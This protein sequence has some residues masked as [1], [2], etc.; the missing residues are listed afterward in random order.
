MNNK[1]RLAKNA[2]LG[3]GCFWKHPES[4][5]FNLVY[6]SI[7]RPW[8]SYKKQLWDLSDPRAAN[9][10]LIREANSK[11]VGV[12]NNAK[13]LYQ[14][15]LPVDDIF[16][17]Y[18]NKSSLDVLSQFD[19]YDMLFW[20]LDDGTTIHRND[21]V[22]KDGRKRYRYLLS[23]GSICPTTEEE[24]EVLAILSSIFSIPIAS[25]GSIGLNNSKATNRNKVWRIPVFIA[26]TLINLGQTLNI[27]CF[28][29]KLRT[30]HNQNFNDHPTMGVGAQGKVL[31]S[32]ELP[33]FLVE[34]M[35]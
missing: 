3:D 6:S 32:G 10:S 7:N 17:D 21:Y 33:S 5:R 4:T 13:P 28:P 12:F 35:V 20:F 29:S 16:D 23:I 27:S 30:F 24:Q 19:L 31:R 8:L 15:K 11:K 9:L 34:D 1:H 25:I 26:E 18:F 22:R 2:K 14:L